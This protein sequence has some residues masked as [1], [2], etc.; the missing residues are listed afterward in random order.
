MRSGR[1][2]KIAAGKPPP[3]LDAQCGSP[4]T[5]DTPAAAVQKFGKVGDLRFPGRA[6]QDG[7]A[8]GA[9]SSQ[10]QGLRRSHA[11]EAEGD[12]GPMEAPPARPA[13]AF[14]PRRPAPLPPSG[15]DLPDVSRWGGRRYCTRRAAKSRPGPAAP[16][17]VHRRGWRPAFVPRFLPEGCCLRA[18][19][20]PRCLPPAS[21][22]RTLRPAAARGCIPR[23]TASA[24]PAAAPVPGRA[25]PPQ[26]A[27]VR[28]FSPP[29]L[30]P[31]RS[32]AVRPSPKSARSAVSLSAAPIPQ[33]IPTICKSRDGCHAGR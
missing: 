19:R 26:G 15:P 8:S 18:S 28:C 21:R 30:P 6:P 31:C 10:Q 17:A 11:G 22:Q 2:E 7:G 14:P 24:R 13:P 32:A 25:V 4:R 1:G 9:D 23:P 33:K 3:P 20:P 5:L 16:A 12:V 29:V 27:E